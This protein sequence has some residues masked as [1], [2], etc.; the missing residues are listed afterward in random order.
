[1]DRGVRHLWRRLPGI[2][3]HGLIHYWC[4]LPSLGA[5]DIFEESAPPAREPPMS[6][7]N[8]P[9]QPGEITGLLRQAAGGLGDAHDRLIPLV[10]Q[11]LNRLAHAR[12]RREPDGHTLNTTALVHE[13]WLRLADQRRVE[14]QSRQHFFAVAS[15]AM[16]RILIDHAKRHRATKRGAGAPHLPL[17]A[18]ADR[19]AGQD[20]M[21]DDQADELV[22]L[23]EALHRLA[24]FNPEGAR[25]IQYRFFGGL[26]HPEIAGVLG[27]SERTVRRVWV[28]AKAWLRQELGDRL[29][30]GWL[31]TGPAAP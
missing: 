16:R 26:S 13:A 31:T 10:Y 12:L 4:R 9:D 8:P 27:I 7:P 17:E 22:A 15:E 25:I 11:E 3:T 19:V 24:A 1:M 20:I 2:A 21:T 30:A 5:P 18:I 14:W 23:D 6:D 28:A 29:T